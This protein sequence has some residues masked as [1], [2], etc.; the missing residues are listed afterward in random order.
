M[1]AGAEARQYVNLNRRR[2]D[3]VVKSLDDAL[4]LA[5]YNETQP[6]NANSNTRY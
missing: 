5:N 1:T 6:S 3:R 4:D 2:K